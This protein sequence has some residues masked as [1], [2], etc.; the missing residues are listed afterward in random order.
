MATNPAGADPAYGDISNT[1]G[2]IYETYRSDTTVSTP[3][4]S[5]T[6]AQL[7]DLINAAVYGAGAVATATVGKATSV[8]AS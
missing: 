6:A 8:E 5:Y 3:N 1:P 2:F 4:A 7:V